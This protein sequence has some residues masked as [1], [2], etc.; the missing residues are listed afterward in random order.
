[1]LGRARTTHENHPTSVIIDKQSAAAPL[2]ELLGIQ[3]P[4]LTQAFCL[5]NYSSGAKTLP[6]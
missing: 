1:M 2:A 6:P 3:P 4:F 5:N